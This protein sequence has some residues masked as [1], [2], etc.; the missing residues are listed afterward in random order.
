MRRETV[1]WSSLAMSCVGLVLLFLTSPEVSPQQLE[2]QGEVLSVREHGGVSFVSFVPGNVTVV[3]FEE[4]DWSEG[5]HVLIGRL[6]QYKGKVE[7][8]VE[9]VR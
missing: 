3:S 7:F 1:L 6:Q 2:W 9:D 4:L 8:V 5:Y